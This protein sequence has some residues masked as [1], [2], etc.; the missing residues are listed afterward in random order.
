MSAWLAMHRLDALS[1]A[2]AFAAGVIALAVIQGIVL[3]CW[4]LLGRRPDTDARWQSPANPQRQRDD[5]ER[6]RAACDASAAN[7]ESGVARLKQTALERVRELERAASELRRV[8]RELKDKAA[9]IGALERAKSDL[10]LWRERHLLV[11]KRKD[12][13]LGASADA[14]ATAEQTI[15]LLRGMIDPLGRAR[16]PMPRRIPH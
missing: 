16:V 8:R 12:E 15:A 9:T 11:L 2:V 13:E 1:P 10:E 3:A 6:L 14:L 7:L 5:I 4:K